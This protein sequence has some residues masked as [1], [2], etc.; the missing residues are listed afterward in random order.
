MGE[1][2]N[3]TLLNDILCRKA[4]WIG[5]ILRR[6]LLLHYAIEEQMTELK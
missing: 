4:N 3:G 2:L 5:Y 1:S 6:N